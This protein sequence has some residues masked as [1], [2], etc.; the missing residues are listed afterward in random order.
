[1]KSKRFWSV[2][3]LRLN[4]LIFR[5]LAQLDPEEYRSSVYRNIHKHLGKRLHQLVKAAEWKFT[6]SNEPIENTVIEGDIHASTVLMKTLEEVKNVSYGMLKRLEALD[7]VCHRKIWDF[8][9]FFFLMY[10]LDFQPSTTGKPK[11]GRKWMYFAGVGTLIG[12]S[13]WL[14]YKWLATK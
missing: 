3:R 8:D 5:Y 1:M 6:E 4:S 9:C 12:C 14:A 7:E 10:A 13:G 2:V 11:Q